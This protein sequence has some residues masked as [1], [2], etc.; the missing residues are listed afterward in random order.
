MWGGK[1]GKFWLD[2]WTIEEIGPINVIRRPGTPVAVRSEDGAT[3]YEEGRDFAKLIDPEYNPYRVPEGPAPAL[4]LTP[5]SRIKPGQRLK[6][7]W[8]HSM[9]IHDSQV[10][11]CMAEP[12]IYEI[13]DHEA[14]L[15]AEHLHP[16]KIMLGMDEVRM[17]GTCKACYG[18]NMGELL[19]ECVT[20]QAQSLRKYSPGAKIYV[21][22]DMLD[23]YHNAVKDYYLV[24]G[25]FTG[26]WN[27]IPKDMTIA[28]WGGEPREKNL[29][30]FA[31][32]G[33]ETL[34]ACYYDAPN[35]DEVKGWIKMA[36]PLPK[37]RGFMYT[38][39]TRKY[40]LIPEFGKLLGGQQ[41]SGSCAA[42]R[43]TRR[44][45]VRRTS[46]PAKAD[47]YAA[48]RHLHLPRPRRDVVH[49]R[50]RR[51]VL[52]LQRRHQGLEIQGP[53]RLATAGLRLEIRLQPL[54]QE[55]SRRKSR[56]GPRKSTISKATSG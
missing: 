38:P 43:Q 12:E 33:F 31:D 1:S 6:V 26:S 4:K 42:E 47:G 11:L 41:E 2:D 23:P 16:K 51:A 49:D 34:C 35:L 28:V 55:I 14:K 3:T 40:D 8:Y 54:A 20:R 52:G 19:G 25:D 32:Q 10:T 24:R 18:R 5:D 29:K 53:Q 15:L 46:R 17:G 7:S 56:S 21:W 48:A 22:S 44:N 13:I 39:W 27:H 50:H 9:L 37:V 45:Q 36:T 30:F